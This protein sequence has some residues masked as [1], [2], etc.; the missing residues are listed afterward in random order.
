MKRAISAALLK[1][2]M[3]YIHKDPEKNLLNLATWAENFISNPTHRNQLE[4]FKKAASNP[5]S[6]EYAFIM[7]VI[8]ETD[9]HILDKF[10][11]NFVINSAWIGNQHLRDLREQYQMNIPWTILIDPTSACNLHCIGCWAAEYKRTDSLSFELIDR[12]ITEGKKLGI[13]TYLYSGGEP[14][15]RKADLVGLAAKH[16]DA[17]FAAFTNATLIDEKFAYDLVQVGNFVPIISIEGTEE[18]TDARRGKGVYAACISAMDILHAKGVPFGFSTCYHKNNTETVGSDAYID[19]LTEKGALFGWYF[20]YIPTG[21]NAVTDLI[22][23]PQQREFMFHRVRE[24][25]KSKPIFVLDFW[26]DGEYVDGCIAGGR[27][28]FHINA[29]GDVEPCAFIHYSNVNI[30]DRSLLEALDN[31]L[32]RE[33]RKHQ[34]CNSN[35]H[36]PC[37]MFDN[38]EILV[39]M[40]HNSNAVSTQPIDKES[41]E[42]LYDKCKPAA[43][44]WAP[45]ADVLW[46]T[47]RAK[48]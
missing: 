1:K 20:T 22:A 27:N 44:A 38:P 28:Y 33:Y 45:V 7:R 13:Y 36:R 5:D 30:K 21:K 25:R 40:V 34:P 41:V 16:S 14:L 9:P 47:C 17:V 12:I 3:Q 35:M 39:E 42:E 29:H 24:I 26:N 10:I 23:T 18:E 37:P 6:S 8:H 2:G 19:L 46:K 4:V 48:K 11:T 31:P 43:D 32:F 15:L